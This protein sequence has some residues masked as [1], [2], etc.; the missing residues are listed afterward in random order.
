VSDCLENTSYSNIC[1]NDW[2]RMND[3]RL[4]S[5]LLI[6]HPWRA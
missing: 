6:I 4:C 5:L 1:C 3:N 2:P